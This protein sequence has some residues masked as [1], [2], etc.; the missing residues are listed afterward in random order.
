MMARHLIE[1]RARSPKA[2]ASFRA[3]GYAW[4]RVAS[5]PARWV[6]RRRPG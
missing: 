3:E 5:T 6:F 4:D 1:E 2:M